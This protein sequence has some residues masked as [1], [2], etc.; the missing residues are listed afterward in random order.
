MCYP[1]CRYYKGKVR[2]SSSVVYGLIRFA[3]R[4]AIWKEN[5]VRVKWNEEGTSSR[6]MIFNRIFGFHVR[7]EFL[8]FF[9][10]SVC[11]CGSDVWNSRQDN[12]H[13]PLSYTHFPSSTLQFFFFSPKNFSGGCSLTT[14][15]PTDGANNLEEEEEKILWFVLAVLRIPPNLLAHRLAEFSC[16]SLRVMRDPLRR[17]LA[18]GA[19][20]AAVS[21][22]TWRR[23]TTRLLC[24]GLPFPLDQVMMAAR[25]LP[26]SST[27]F[28]LELVR[29]LTNVPTGLLYI[30]E[31]ILFY[32]TDS[33][34]LNLFFLERH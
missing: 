13:Q 3:W 25:Q 21:T 30:I 27:F 34:S 32:L 24:C 18:S 9:P 26:I 28:V 19:K 29:L 23:K 4:K 20:W 5:V 17:W 14:T 33:A 2:T 8:I 15:D 7:H 10:P 16:P 22:R 1:S 31:G 11:L 6:G 12:L